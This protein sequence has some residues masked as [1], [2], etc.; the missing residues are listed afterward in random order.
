MDTW[1]EDKCGIKFTD[2]VIKPFLQSIYNLIRNYRIE[3]VEKIDLSNYTLDQNIDY[4]KLLLNT[5]NFESGLIRN[6]FIKPILRE[7]APY[8]RYVQKEL[9]QLDKMDELQITQDEID[10][11]EEIDSLEKFKE[12]LQNLDNFS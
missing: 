4:N 7:L 1:T 6:E 9:E 5:Y 8:L 10:L 2:L 12:E 3:Y 11:V